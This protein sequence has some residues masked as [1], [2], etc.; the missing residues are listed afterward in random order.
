MSRRY[1]FLDGETA[2]LV[3]GEAILDIGEDAFSVE[4][5]ESGTV[6]L[7]MG[8]PYDCAAVL[9]GTRQGIARTLRDWLEL[10]EHA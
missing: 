2:Q 1:E 5:V 7:V 4:E 6:A 3:T 8:D 10:V 9:Y